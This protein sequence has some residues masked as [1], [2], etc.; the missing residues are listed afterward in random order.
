MVALQLQH[1][2]LK[3]IADRTLVG[4]VD[5]HTDKI[6]AQYARQSEAPK[7]LCRD[8]LCTSEVHAR[9]VGFFSEGSWHG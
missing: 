6:Y 7:M 1:G 3:L 8:L 2:V 4:F 9:K 5:T